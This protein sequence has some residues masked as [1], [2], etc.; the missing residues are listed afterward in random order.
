MGKRSHPI[1][2]ETVVAERKIT[3]LSEPG[4]VTTTRRARE[5]LMGPRCGPLADADAAAG[6][7]PPRRESVFKL[8]TLTIWGGRCDGRDMTYPKSRSAAARGRRRRVTV[9]YNIYIVDV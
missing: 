8:C 2:T 4:V 7:F 6:M 5:R 9:L 3:A 1:R